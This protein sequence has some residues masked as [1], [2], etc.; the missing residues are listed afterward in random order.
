M[1]NFGE[2]KRDIFKQYIKLKGKLWVEWENLEEEE[3]PESEENEEESEFPLMSNTGH[4]LKILLP[5]TNPT[6]S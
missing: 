3:E 6:G 2:D 4:P 5:P 1:Q